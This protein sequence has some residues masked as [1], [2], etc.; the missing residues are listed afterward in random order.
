MP[1]LPHRGLT[2]CRPVCPPSERR[3]DQAAGCRIRLPRATV[4]LRA[5]RRGTRRPPRL[6]PSIPAERATRA[7]RRSRT[8][9]SP[10]PRQPSPCHRKTCRRPDGGLIGEGPNVVEK[11]A[12]QGPT[13]PA[14][15]PPPALGPQH[16]PG[17]HPG[18]RLGPRHG[19]R[20]EPAHCQRHAHRIPCG[21]RLKKYGSHVADEGRLPAHLKSPFQAPLSP[22]Q[23]SNMSPILQISDPAATNI[24]SRGRSCCDGP[25]TLQ[26]SIR[27]V[28]RSLGNHQ[29]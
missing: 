17:S 12:P 2:A 23:P 18:R 6:P 7:G 13:T 5:P 19:Q 15:R 28:G 22:E 8:E 4:D 10:A 14:L 1:H 20:T 25:P 9:Y 3:R 29:P 21:R 11:L 27:T 26:V 16:Q 24:A